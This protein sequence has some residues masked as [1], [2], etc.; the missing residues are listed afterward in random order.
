MLTWDRQQQLDYEDSTWY[1]RQPFV[2]KVQI[3]FDSYVSAKGTVVGNATAGTGKE[4]DCYKI[5]RAQIWKPADLGANGTCTSDY[6]C[7]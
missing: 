1:A 2:L 5:N 3:N 7:Y 4:F 6:A